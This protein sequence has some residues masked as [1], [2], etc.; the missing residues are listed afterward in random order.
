M[1]TSSPGKKPV[2]WGRRMLEGALDL[3]GSRVGY[4]LGCSLPMGWAWLRTGCQG[5][6]SRGNR[7]GQV[8]ERGSLRGCSGGP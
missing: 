3:R 8:W 4:C 6:E 1:M 2:L 7:D 5:N